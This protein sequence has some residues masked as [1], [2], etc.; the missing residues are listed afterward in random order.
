M[1]GCSKFVSKNFAT[2]KRSILNSETV[3]VPVR[4]SGAEP[5]P[6][7]AG[8]P[9]IPEPRLPAVAIVSLRVNEDLP[10]EPTPTPQPALTPA[11]T[12]ATA[13]MATISVATKCKF[14]IIES[15]DIVFGGT[16]TEMIYCSNL[17][18]QTEIRLTGTK[19]GIQDIDKAIAVTNPVTNPYSK[20]NYGDFYFSE[21]RRNDGAEKVG[22]YTR[23]IV[24]KDTFSTN[25]IILDER[26][27]AFLPD[28]GCVVTVTE[29][30][31]GYVVENADCKYVPAGAFVSLYWP[32][33]DGS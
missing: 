32:K 17:N 8:I 20:E 16:I 29:T 2:G 18:A 13:P 9:V 31:P 15:R 4:Y 6:N 28:L 14:R 10:P 22:A 23:Q 33:E 7:P 11:Q 19:N 30:A 1:Q 27:Y 25:V 24:L 26:R 3:P 5:I 12:P 21:T